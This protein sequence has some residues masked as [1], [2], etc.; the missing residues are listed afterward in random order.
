MRILMMAVV[1]VSM[2]TT[3]ACNEDTVIATIDGADA[4]MIGMVRRMP[5]LVAD[6]AVVPQ[7][8]AQV[9]QPSEPDA[10]AIDAMS[11]EPDT[12]PVCVGTAEACDGRDNDCDG[13]IDNGQVCGHVSGTNAGH[14][15]LYMGAFVLTW[16][17]ARAFCRDIG[18]DLVSIETAEEWAWL[19]PW[20]VTNAYDAQFWIGLQ[21][22]SEM[23]PWVWVSG[24][25]GDFVVWRDGQPDNATGAE[26][27][28]D[29]RMQPD[30]T[31]IWSDRPCDGFMSAEVYTL[32][33]AAP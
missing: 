4:G 11:L 6:A 8:D 19:E 25:P 32:C 17:L 13:V 33:E 23:A 21:R 16:D 9:A 22:E 30:E 29:V 10:M 31:F 24:E 2:L 27:C 15:Y 26:N 5:P 7:L 18:Y 14:T 20:L 1:W 28:A 3:T 12:R